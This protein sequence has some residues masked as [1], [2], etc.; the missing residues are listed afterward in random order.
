MAPGGP[1]GVLARG[2]VSVLLGFELDLVGSFP[3]HLEGLLL[4]GVQELGCGSG[5]GVVGG[6]D[7][8]RL[9]QGD[10]AGLEDVPDLLGVAEGPARLHG[11]F[12]FAHRGATGARHLGDV[13]EPCCQ[14]GLA[15]GRE[16]L[17]PGIRGE[18][19][20][21]RLRAQKLGLGIRVGFLQPA[22]RFGDRSALHSFILTGGCDKEPFLSGRRVKI[23]RF[24]YRCHFSRGPC[25]DCRVAPCAS[26]A[27]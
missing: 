13:V 27:L 16:L 8:T 25:L 22:D 10:G 20:A 23:S 7:L 1:G 3:E 19:V 9:I 11:G 4:G 14:H 15:V 21:G 2:E 6:G 5:T 24:L 18:Q 17:G 26:L 12:G